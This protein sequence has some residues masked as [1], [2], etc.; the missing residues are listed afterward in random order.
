MSTPTDTNVALV[1]GF[2][3]KET[4]LSLQFLRELQ[5]YR[6]TERATLMYTIGRNQAALDDALRS[7]HWVNAA[8]HAL[9][10]AACSFIYSQ[11]VD[12]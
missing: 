4:G 8:G 1:N 3:T 12:Y 6:K 11:Q 5:T 9:V 10:I 7:G 2:S